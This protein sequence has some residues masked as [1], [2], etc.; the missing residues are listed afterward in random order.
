MSYKRKG[1]SGIIDNKANT[2]Y[3][4]F[5]YLMDYLEELKQAAASAAASAAAGTS[6]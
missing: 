6:I 4:K 2:V 1:R 3:D 5:E